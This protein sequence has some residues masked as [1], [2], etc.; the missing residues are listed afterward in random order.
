MPDSRSK[1][2]KTICQQFR[3]NA[4]PAL[5]DF[6]NLFKVT[7]I[8]FLSWNNI[9]SLDGAVGAPVRSVV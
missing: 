6:S 8:K 5:H 4:V 3:V 1:N 2:K 7:E 9:I